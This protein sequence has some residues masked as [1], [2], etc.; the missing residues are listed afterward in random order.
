MPSGGGVGAAPLRGPNLSGNSKPNETRSG[1]GTRLSAA[2]SPSQ[3]AAG[4]PG[5]SQR[6]RPL[7]APRP[8]LHSTGRALALPFLPPFRKLGRPRSARVGGGALQPLLGTLEKPPL[9]GRLRRASCV[10]LVFFQKQKIFGPAG[11]G[12]GMLQSAAALFRRPR[13]RVCGGIFELRWGIQVSSC[14]VPGKSI[15]PFE[16]RGKIGRA[17]V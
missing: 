13:G 8:H 11:C 6:P 2:R 14:I 9:P 5:L 17:H 3:H 1:L 16:V 12:A 7:P 15:L 10:P 4:S